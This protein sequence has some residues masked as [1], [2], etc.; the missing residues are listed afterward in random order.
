MRSVLFTGGAGA[1]GS[2]L[3]PDL[4]RDHRCVVIVREGSK[5]PSALTDVSNVTLIEGDLSSA[6]AA[7][8]VIRRSIE[9]VGPLFGVV[10]LVGGFAMGKI[11]ET[12]EESWRLM[13]ELNVTTAF[14]VFRALIPHL[15][16]NG[17]GRLIAM[18]SIASTQNNPALAAYTVGKSALNTMVS[19][20]AEDLKGS[21]VTANLLMPGS[22]KTAVAPA[23]D[24]SLLP[25]SE[26]AASVRYLLS[27]DAKHVNGA[28]IR[29]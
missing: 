10:Q 25:I 11:E 2:E 20:A 22:M 12:S 7:D 5:I 24:P 19:L 17:E 29:F 21:G 23:N 8:D 18:S 16:Q 27:D 28:Q 13:L 6:A 4:A 3:V 26:I 1:V 14:F 9:K 15:R